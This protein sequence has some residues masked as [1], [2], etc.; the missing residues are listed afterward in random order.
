MQNTVSSIL[1]TCG[2]NLIQTNAGCEFML[3][4]KN[5][6]GLGNLRIVCPPQTLNAALPPPL[7]ADWDIG[8]DVTIISGIR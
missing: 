3:M 2:G 5:A 7:A 1:V 8:K 4:R 6:Q